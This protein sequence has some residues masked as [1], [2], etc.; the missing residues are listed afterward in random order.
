MDLIEAIHTRRSIR[1]FI[2]KEISRELLREI[3][4]AGMYAP[5]ARNYQPW[6]FIVIESRK[7]LNKIPEV[8]PYAEMVPDSAVS[9]C[10]CGDL[11]IEK[12]PEYNAVN[13]SAVTQNMLL[14]AHNFGIGSVWLGVYP[15]EERIKGL[16]NLLSLPD[17]VLPVSLIAFGY[18][19]EFK[20][21]PDRFLPDR[22]HTN[23]W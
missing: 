14:A 17:Y 18:P 11:S 21:T 8:H 2:D 4:K 1:K 9:I 6:H 15:R 10:V 3:L 23:R 7:L 19:D 16:K 12:S 20:S 13:C 22:I 5:S